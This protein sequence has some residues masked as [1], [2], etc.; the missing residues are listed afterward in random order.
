MVRTKGNGTDLFEEMVAV[1]VL[2]VFRGL[3]FHP[4]VVDDG[5]AVG[6]LVGNPQFVGASGMEFQVGWAF[7]VI[8]CVSDHG[9]FEHHAKFLDHHRF[10][11][12]GC[13]DGKGNE[14]DDKHPCHQSGSQH[15]LNA[16]MVDTLF[17]ASTVSAVRQD[18][19]ATSGLKS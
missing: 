2:S 9:F 1:S 11:R 13:A 7:E 18:G 12:V 14:H 8:G 4:R 3:V 17:L 15:E 5:H 6:V 16:A 10:G 19:K